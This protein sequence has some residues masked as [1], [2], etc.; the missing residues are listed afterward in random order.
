MC[1]CDMFPDTHP[2]GQILDGITCEL[3][4][5]PGPAGTPGAVPQISPHLANALALGGG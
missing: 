1:T 3:V 2:D 5:R 4:L